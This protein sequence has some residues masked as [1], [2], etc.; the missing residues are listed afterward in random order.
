M[1]QQNGSVTPPVVNQPVGQNQAAGNGVPTGRNMDELKTDRSNSKR[2]LTKCINKVR[3]IISED[4]LSK[5]SQEV[6]NLKL[7]FQN[8]ENV[9]DRYIEGL[10]DDPAVEE[11]EKY[12][13]EE[14]EMYIGVMNEVKQ[15]KSS[16]TQV[17]ASKEIINSLNLPRVVL[18]PFD[19]TDPKKFH[20]FMS[21]FD[22]S[23]D[24]KTS[25][26]HLKLTRLLQFTEGMA[27]RAIESTTLI[28]GSEGYAQA[29]KILHKRFGDDFL[30]SEN[31][32]KEFKKESP[33]T[34]D[35]KLLEFSDYLQTSSVI[36][37]KLNRYREVDTQG[38]QLTIVSR[39]P[40]LMKKK[41]KQ[42][43]FDFKEKTGDYPSMD[44]LI[45][46]IVYFANLGSDPVLSRIT[47]SEDSNSKKG[48]QR[49]QSSAAANLPKS[50]NMMTSAR[51]PVPCPVCQAEHRVIFCDRFKGMSLPERKKVVREHRLCELCLIKGHF[52]RDCKSP[53]QCKVKGCKKKHSNLLHQTG[54][55]HGHTVT[56]VDGRTFLP[57]V[58]L[59]INGVTTCALLDTASNNTFCSKDLLRRLR[60]QGSPVTFLLTTLDGTNP[61]ETVWAKLDARSMDG[62]EQMPFERVYSVDKIPIENYVPPDRSGL[63]THLRDI[64][65][66]SGQVD[67]IIG[68]DNC[69]AF[70]PLEVRKSMKRNEAFAVRTL[71]GWCLNGP[72][73]SNQSA[74]SNRVISQFITL[75][76]F[77][78]SNEPADD[79][80]KLYEIDNEGLVSE[81]DALSVSDQKVLDLW[82]KECRI[83]D[84]HYELPIPWKDS[85]MVVPNNLFVARKRLYNLKQSLL[86]R[87]LYSR[88]NTEMMKL[89][90][91]GYAE[92][93][94][95]CDVNKAHDVRYLPT[96]VVITD[97]KPDKARPVFD[98]ASKFRGVSLNDMCLQGPDLIN[99]LLHVLLRFREHETVVMGDIESMYN[100]VRIPEKDRDFLR[101]IWF[102]SNGKEVVLRM[103]SHL[104]GGVWCASSSTYALRKAVEDQDVSSLVRD[105]VKRS[106]YV[107]D[108][109]RSV[110]DKSDAEVVV[111]ETKAALAERGFNL[112]KFV[113]N[114]LELLSK[115]PEK[116]RASGESQ[117]HSRALGVSWNL[118]ND[119][120]ELTIDTEGVDSCVVTRRVML[121][122]IASVY[123]PL[124]LANPLLLQGKLLLQDATRMKLSWD[125]SAP[126]S[127][128]SEWSKWVQKLK[129]EA[130]VFAVPRCLKP[131]FYNDA[132]LEL[133]HFSDG[134]ERAYG[135]CS[136]LRCVNKNGGI[137]VALIISKMKLVP[138]R[139][140]VSVPRAELEAGVMSAK[141]DVLLRKEMDLDFDRSYFWTDSE[142]LLKYLNN[143][144]RRFKVYVSNRLA[145]IHEASRPEQWQHIAGVN[146][147]ADQ[148]TKA[149]PNDVDWIAGPEFLSRHKSEWPA[150]KSVDSVI[151][152]DDPE[153]RVETSAFV[154]VGVE[155]EHPI[156]KMLKHYSS[157]YRLKKAVAWWVRLKDSLLKRPRAESRFLSVEELKS[158]ELMI[159]KRVQDEHYGEEIDRLQRGDRISKASGLAKLMPR[160][161]DGV[162]VVGGR[163]VNA[164]VGDEAK[165]PVLIPQK[166]PLS[167]LLARQ[168]HNKAHL[169][170]E[171]VLGLIR[172]RYWI[173]KGRVVVKNI[174]RSCVVCKRLYAKPLDQLMAD[175][176]IE[177]L[178]MKPPFS[179]TG[180]DCFGN[181]YVSVGR[182][183][184]KRYGCLFTCLSTRA[185]HLEK[186]TNMDTESFINCLKRFTSR[187]GPP[188]KLACDPG[189]NFVGAESELKEEYAKL[190]FEEIELY[191][192]SQEIE[193]K[194]NVPKASHAGGAWE[195]CIR[196][197]R[198]VLNALLLE[199][200]TLTDEILDTLFCIVENIV[201]N[202][203][204][205]YCSED[206][207]DLSPL[208]PNHILRLNGSDALALPGKFCARDRYRSRWRFVQHLS[209]QFWSRWLKEYIPELQR[210]AKWLEPK[211]NLKVGD[212]VLLVD[213]STPRGLWPMGR[214]MNVKESGDFKVRSAEVKTRT[215]VLKR[216]ITKI[217][218]LEGEL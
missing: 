103:C 213:E 156:D 73:T 141:I 128:S 49:G 201:N 126:E 212:L 105:C 23:V 159:V 135:M 191:C 214:I 132:L 60:L 65:L 25:D 21:L 13:E 210:R 115:I 170:T 111:F 71:F 88:Y 48:Q 113:T 29:R 69:E 28:G 18:T 47:T 62:E 54:D 116:D 167:K 100:Q 93:V 95:S 11:A 202:R 83:V 133:H 193:W 91:K 59:K 174:G 129:K 42:K 184:V 125:A 203:P 172:Q 101:F 171:W 82:D 144:S 168:Y 175:L 182:S 195:R 140:G 97:K 173:T 36:L 84:G 216:P 32:I 143:E 66:V 56:G 119:A 153:L 166:S 30:V 215:T 162:L 188:E 137:N 22:E 68:Q 205:T 189:T 176:P 80:N 96:Q 53:Y 121:S 120:F 99:R 152:Q 163:L 187:R 136:Y 74:A 145:K 218:L 217:V 16:C 81:D 208:T 185:V 52:W 24:S 160:L 158:A 3:R 178:A 46:F 39:L 102:D 61:V 4:D 161:K 5:L 179:N 150:V 127:I 15:S 55:F 14:Q 9:C 180:V 70:I 41:W 164:P 151:P 33:I 77:I 85:D 190:K 204:L 123:D 109:L 207:N 72:S 37:K 6:S 157:M 87:G 106:F 58:K 198:R 19:G 169:G 206:P 63:G 196:T 138:S 7:V 112:T 98:C 110:Q 104:F 78:R 44:A 20:I 124:G 200:G 148:L 43:A 64:P 194:L 181:F 45:N 118:K 183:S 94:P 149:K 38:T 114:D 34:S 146:N 57:V 139:G 86:K 51:D 12:F 76:F 131:A 1:S 31:I 147:P 211:R 192:R 35:T 40:D 154:T 89:V 10:N 90:E 186:L 67:L 108:L 142:I 209:D 17:D 134:G 122:F 199:Y 8:F 130:D 50:H 177:R 79:I 107:D 26:D 2:S 27:Y 75:S 155:Y 197:V 165:C 92:V 117:S